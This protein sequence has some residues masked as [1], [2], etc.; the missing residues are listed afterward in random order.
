MCLLPDQ[1]LLIWGRK[2]GEQLPTTPLATL[3]SPGADYSYQDF[4]TGNAANLNTDLFCAGMTTLED[5]RLFA[6]GGQL[7]ENEYGDDAVNVFDFSD[8]TN[9]W[10]TSANRMTQFRWYP[11]TVALPNGRVIVFEG[12]GGPLH[13][14]SEIPELWVFGLPWDTGSPL[15]EYS[16]SF[17][18]RAK[19]DKW[20]PHI[21]IDPKDGNLFFAAMGRGDEF[22]YA[23]QKLNLIDLTWTYPYSVYGT[24]LNVRRQLPS[25]VMINARNWAG[26]REAILVRSGGSAFGADSKAAREALYTD[27][28]GDPPAWR[29]AQSMNLP[30]ISHTLV[31]LPTGD[32]VAMG[33][34]S[35]HGPSGV[36][37]LNQ[38]LPQNAPELWNPFVE[39]RDA[40][41]WQLLS[42]PQELVARG[43]HST[44]LLLPDAR[45]MQAGG[46]PNT[47]RPGYLQQRN[48]Q[49]FAPGYGGVEDWQ[50]KRP[51]IG[52]DCPAVIR[53]GE[54]FSAHFLPSVKTQNPIR[55]LMLISIGST[56]HAFNQRQNVYELDFTRN[57][58]GSLTVTPPEAPK[59]APPGYY[60]LFAVDNTDLGEPT[61]TRIVGIPSIAKIV[62]LRDWDRVFVTGGSLETGTTQRSID[63][64]HPYDLVLSDNKYLGG[65]LRFG[66]DSEQTASVVFRSVM[67]DPSPAKIRLSIEAKTS[68]PSSMTV[69]VLDSATGQWAPCGNPVNF[70]QGE[71]KVEIAVPT[72]VDTIDDL[73][74]MYVRVSFLLAS[75]G[76]RSPTVYIDSFETN[77][78]SAL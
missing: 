2:D 42:A 45:I 7:I 74:N 46:E 61:T 8:P 48:A 55:K 1:R 5:G 4:V 14:K 31:A 71:K 34:S 17:T 26:T 77:Y 76:S 50:T 64:I 37:P 67:P 18:P 47:P 58:D 33:G 68:D 6:A 3:V 11:T 22:A 57:Q 49:I 32:V 72:E 23:N 63:W 28:Y 65:Y 66:G 27:M 39:D 52:E 40:R 16:A 10:T 12:T 78:R 19:V 59:L 25:S 53:Y 38:A 51:T 35:I 15:H 69:Q 41:P 56:T 36:P 20:Y 21:F 13:L 43:Y 60:M 44:A 9:T 30:R 73:G 75:A 54:P 62:H 24:V 29:Q 70:V